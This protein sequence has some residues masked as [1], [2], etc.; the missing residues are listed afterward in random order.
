MLNP[1]LLIS[2]IATAMVYVLSTYGLLVT[3]RVA[4]V[5]NLAFGYQAALAA[6]LYWQ[7]NV[8]WNLPAILSAVIVVFVAGPLMGFA[9]QRI[10]FRRRREV[11]SSI[12]LTLGLG[13]FINGIIQVLWNSSVVR[14]VPSIFGS[15]FWRIGSTSIL[16]ND[17]GVIAAATVIGLLVW[18][19]LNRSRLG[20]QMR[21]VVDDPELAGSSGIPE[22]RVSAVAWIIGSM[23][24][25][26]GGIL[27][28]PELSL[29][30]DLL[31]GLVVNAF[32]VFAFAGMKDLRLVV[33]GALLLAYLQGIADKYPHAFAFLGGV[34][35]SAA[36]PF[37]MLAVVLLVHPAAR[38][39]VR[40]IGGGM[41]RR[42]RARASGN[43]S[44]AIALTVVLTVVA[45]LL[46]P[47]WAF[48]GE[49]VACYAIVGLS[50]VL[51]VGASGQISLCQ[52]TFMGLSAVMLGK[53][54]GHG[55]P[56]GVAL[57]AGIATAAVAG[58]LISLTAF[59]LRGLFLALITYAFAY[60][61]TYL[62][63]GNQQIISY[64]GLSVNRPN[65]FGINMA[66]DRNF[67]LFI[68]VILIITILFVGALLRGPWGRALQTLSAGD[69]VASVSG[70]PVRGWKMSVFT[71]SAALAGL[72]GGLFAAVNITVTG[73]SFTASQSIFVL[74]YA[75]VGGITTPVGAIVAGVIAQAGGPI[76]QLFIS[77]AGA[78]I[79]VLFGF[80]AMDTTLRYPAGLGGLLPQ[81][82]PGVS[83][84]GRR[85][86]RSQAPPSGQ[87]AALP[88]TGGTR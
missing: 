37:V 21:A 35:A 4:G 72:A 3:Y 32:A 83:A 22:S 14:T 87:D 47:V 82:L 26:V 65:F 33:V 23:L 61:A 79:F 27:L 36:L 17:V 42:L 56:F 69:S 66:D 71:V 62:V 58:M 16:H 20:L 40:V 51:L 75:V 8:Q 60:G 41:Q 64:A 10:L 15:G 53:L 54:T 57:L 24:A 49:Q 70:L 28:A 30:V 19:L 88:L 85:L 67:L 77:N 73:D 68:V 34:S 13:V 18:I 1:T 78:W 39:T 63:F 29:D 46:N 31:T 52:V 6:F 59:R 12:I 86:R 9:I 5:F 76:L 11:L 2:V 50:L 81:K 25:A 80:M 45:E 48:T 7:L 55:V 38:Q 74:V 84:L 44:V 43:V